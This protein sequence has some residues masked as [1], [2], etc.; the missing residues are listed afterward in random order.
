MIALAFETCHHDFI[1]EGDEIHCHRC[2]WSVT[3]YRAPSASFDS[4]QAVHRIQP[5][6]RGL[7]TFLS[8]GNFREILRPGLKVEGK[9]ADVARRALRLYREATRKGDPLV[10]GILSDVWNYLKEKMPRDEVSDVG[11]RLVLQEVKRFRSE[12]PD[13]NPRGLR[14]QL[15]KRVVARLEELEPLLSGERG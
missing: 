12:Y 13:L 1:A 15:V 9:G 8:P 6:T 3:A 4:S 14:A 2:G 5:G 11:A 10:E 7:G